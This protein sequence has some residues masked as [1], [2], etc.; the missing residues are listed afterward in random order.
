MPTRPHILLIDNYDSFVWNLAQAFQAAGASVQVVRHDEISP[1]D[2]GTTAATH[3][4]I[5]PGPKTPDQAGA[6]NDIIRAWHGRLPILGVC[7][8]HQC[9]ARVLGAQ[10]R[11]VS[12]RHGR[13]SRVMHDGSAL[14]N[15][16]PQPMIAARYHSLGVVPGTLPTSVRVTAW[17]EDEQNLPLPQRM[18]MAMEVIDAPS[19]VAVQFHPESFLTPDGPQLLANFM[20]MTATPVPLPVPTPVSSPLSSSVPTT[21]SSAR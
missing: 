3:I 1:D 7:L 2:I 19:T 16:V 8:G 20:A 12:P 10:V 15:G 17:L 18:P 21:D 14:F 5:S 9:L 4:C 13:T 11:R 6:S